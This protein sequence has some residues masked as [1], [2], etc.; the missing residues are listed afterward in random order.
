M[1][2]A[3]LLLTA[4]AAAVLLLPT[5]P[6]TPVV[7][8]AAGTGTTTAAPGPGATGVSP[9]EQRLA[10]RVNRARA[11]HGCRALKHR[12]ALHRSARAHSALMAR[13]RRLAHQLPGEAALGSRLAAAGYSPSRRMGE[14]IA[15]G[16]MSAQRT[17]RMW[18]G[19][20]SHRRLLLD[21][22]FRQLGVGI[23]E[24]APGQRWWTVD[25]VR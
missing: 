6:L 2:L 25:L 8:A 15:A 18:L 20:P 23:V 9:V 5:L 16:P 3:A 12:A 4:F 13:H 10:T 1:R 17:L 21:C 19:S 22:K 7:A 14:V 11:Q 24:S